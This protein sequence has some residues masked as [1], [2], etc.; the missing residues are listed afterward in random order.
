MKKTCGIFLVIVLIVLMTA[1]GGGPASDNG[2]STDNSVNSLPENLIILDAGEWP[3][4]EYTAN[5]PQ[6]DSGTVGHGWIDPDNQYCYIE[7]KDVKSATMENWYGLLMNSGFSEV[8]KIAEEINGQDYTST[9]ALLQNDDV[10][11]SMAH[12]STD[13]NEFMLYITRKNEN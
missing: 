5:I 1:C 6:P 9:N 10:T 13:K 3:E 11:V 4:N 12:L 2:I 7:M 8:R